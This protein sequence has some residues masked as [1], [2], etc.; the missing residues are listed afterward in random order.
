M[1]SCNEDVKMTEIF[2]FTHRH[3]MFFIILEINMYM[4]STYY[5]TEVMSHSTVCFKNGGEMQPDMFDYMSEVWSSAEP[6]PVF[7]FSQKTF[8]ISRKSCTKL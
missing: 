4:P 6:P 3:N 2:P 8:L 7:R 1:L 5:F